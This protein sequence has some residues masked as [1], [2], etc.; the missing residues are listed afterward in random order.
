M[1]INSITWLKLQIS[2][3]VKKVQVSCN[4]DHGSYSHRYRL[5]PTSTDEIFYTYFTQTFLR[6]HI[7]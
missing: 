3:K 5:L 2:A 6:F 4:H 1:K 7:D